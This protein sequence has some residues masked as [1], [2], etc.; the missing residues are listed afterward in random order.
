[1]NTDQ[2]PLLICVHLCSSVANSSSSPPAELASGARGSYPSRS[3]V[4]AVFRQRIVGPDMAQRK[5]APAAATTPAQP[6]EA[7]PELEQARAQVALTIC[8]GCEQA[9]TRIVFRVRKEGPNKGRLFAKCT[10]CQRFDWLSDAPVT[11]EPAALVSQPSGDAERDALQASA[12]PCPKCGRPRRAQRVGKKGP[13]HGRLFLSC[14]DR[15]CDSFEWAETNPGTVPG[16]GARGKED[17]GEAGLLQAIREAPDDDAPRLGYADWLDEQ[18]DPRRAERSR[19]QC[20]LARIP[21]GLRASQLRQ[22][23]QELLDE[24]GADWAAP[25]SSFV[26]GSTFRRGLLE[27]VTITP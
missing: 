24:H 8:P 7:D 26:S 27:Q 14:S 18:H 25:L 22:R 23:E 11:A 19:V 12:T 10:Q 16:A 1:M 9:S 4:R 21:L 3:Q 17:T 20:E 15:N 6:A 2:E 13:N 5:K